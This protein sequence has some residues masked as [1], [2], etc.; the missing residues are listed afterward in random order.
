MHVIELDHDGLLTGFF[1]IS[2]L[3]SYSFCS[4]F[5]FRCCVCHGMF[6]TQCSESNDVQPGHS[7][8]F[9]M[10]FCQSQHISNFKEKQP[11]LI[12]EQFI[13][14]SSDREARKL[15]ES[16]ARSANARAMP[17]WSA[18]ILYGQQCFSFSPGVSRTT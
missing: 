18:S 11:F 17:G 9:K 15:E 8:L 2:F 7:F 13:S 1:S 5:N 16:S 10:A 3:A 14:G 12:G 6:M 4:S